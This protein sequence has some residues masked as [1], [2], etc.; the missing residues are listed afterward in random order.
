MGIDKI[1][2]MKDRRNK[3]ISPI[4]VCPDHANMN[5]PDIFYVFMKT[6]LAKLND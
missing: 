6:N 5:T 1:W 2:E 4:F 3:S